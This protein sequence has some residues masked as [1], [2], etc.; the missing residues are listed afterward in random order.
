MFK[1]AE[2]T[3]DGID[4]LALN[5]VILRPLYKWRV[6]H[7]N[8]IC[9]VNTWMTLIPMQVQHP[10]PCQRWKKVKAALS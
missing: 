2:N 7:I 10:T 9:C 4:I 1:F 3:L 8:L 5:H 6:L